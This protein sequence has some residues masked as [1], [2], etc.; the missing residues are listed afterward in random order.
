MAII[1]ISGGFY[2]QWKELLVPKLTPQHTLID[3]EQNDPHRRYPGWYVG[4][5]F[6]HIEGSDI[7]LCVQTD[8]PHLYGMFCEMGY[9]VAKG[10]E[11]IYVVQSPLT[12]VDSFASG[13]AR[14]TFT[15]LMAACDFINARYD[16]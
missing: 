16:Y 9:A 1:Y 6:A 3:P 4:T 5:N 11:V 8:Y 13:C 2:A 14:A 7:I 15:D 12:R 10:K